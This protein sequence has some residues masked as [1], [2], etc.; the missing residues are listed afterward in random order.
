MW[1]FFEDAVMNRL[2]VE[3]IRNQ[4]LDP[5]D[6]DESE[7]QTEACEN[8]EDKFNS[9]PCNYT[10]EHINGNTPAIDALINAR[11]IGAVITVEMQAAVIKELL[12]SVDRAKERFV[13]ERLDDEIAKLEAL[14][15][16]EI[17]DYEN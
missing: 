8:L 1:F 14:H 17:A 6:T 15:D 10:W 9:D 5:F 16:E 2:L 13:E 4:W 12:D 11:A 7:Y 3:E